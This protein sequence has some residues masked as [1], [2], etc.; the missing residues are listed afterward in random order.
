MCSS[1]DD[2][3][4][5]MGQPDNQGPEDYVTGSIFPF[6]KRNKSIENNQIPQNLLNGFIQYNT[7]SKKKQNLFLQ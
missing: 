7:E 2:V 3:I 5:V 4:K 6:F 1:Y